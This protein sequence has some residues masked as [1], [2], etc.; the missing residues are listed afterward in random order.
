MQTQRQTS[1]L[2]SHTCLQDSLSY[3]GVLWVV[4]VQELGA[5]SIVVRPHFMQ[6]DHIGISSEHCPPG[7]LVDLRQLYRDQPP[8][9]VVQPL[10]QPHRDL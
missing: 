9:A 8:L 10:G 4:E 1:G 6:I 3:L 5:K 2:S 7:L